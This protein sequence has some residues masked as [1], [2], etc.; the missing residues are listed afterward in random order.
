MTNLIFGTFLMV[1]IS[2][3]DFAARN[4]IDKADQFTLWQGSIVPVGEYESVATMAVLPAS[5][6]FSY[7][8]TLAL[9]GYSWNMGSSIDYELWL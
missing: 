2:S 6:D 8:R 1:T 7:Y 9:A 3:F 5:Y 4:L